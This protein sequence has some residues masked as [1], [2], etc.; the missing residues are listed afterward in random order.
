MRFYRITVTQTAGWPG[1]G[2]LTAPLTAVIAVKQS[3]STA[4][5]SSL[6]HFRRLLHAS[7]AMV[8]GGGAAT[9]NRGPCRL[10][11]RCAKNKPLGARCVLVQPNERS[12]KPWQRAARSCSRLRLS[13]RNTIHARPVLRWWTGSNAPRREGGIKASISKNTPVSPPSSLLFSSHLFF[14]PEGRLRKKL[15]CYLAC[16][17]ID[18]WFAMCISW[19][20]IY[21]GN[22][23][24]QDFDAYLVSADC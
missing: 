13:F 17:R 9:A 14:L 21:I 11:T 5:L 8:C 22:T 18:I 24:W 23:V 4:L 6:E 1:G 16:F 7:G 2:S 10:H 20:D 3:G 19:P 12:D 15:F